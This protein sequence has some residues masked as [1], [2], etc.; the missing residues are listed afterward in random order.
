MHRIRGRVTRIDKNRVI[1]YKCLF[2]VSMVCSKGSFK[3]DGKGKC[4]VFTA[5]LS[6]RFGWI[7]LRLARSRVESLK[8]HMQEEGRNLKQLL[9]NWA[10]QL[11]YHDYWKPM[12]WVCRGIG[13][14]GGL[15]S[16]DLAC[17]KSWRSQVRLHGCPLSVVSWPWLLPAAQEDF[18]QAGLN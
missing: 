1:E 4:S 12:K 6:F 9:E 11:I 7:F 3:V 13:L 10:I 14:L 18:G 8:K 5:T 2:P 17:A 16:P 15:A